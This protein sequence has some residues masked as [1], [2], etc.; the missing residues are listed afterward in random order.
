MSASTFKQILSDATVGGT[1]SHKDSEASMPRKLVSISSKSSLSDALKVL[2][3]NMIVSVPVIDDGKCVGIVDNIDIINYLNK[4]FENIREWL[5]NS[6]ASV[7]EVLSGILVSEIIDFAHGDPLVVTGEKA[8]I[9]SIMNLLVSGMTHRCVV[10]TQEGYGIISQYDII[11]LLAE[12]LKNNKDLQEE[13]DSIILLDRLNSRSLSD[14]TVTIGATASVFEVL[15]RM[16]QKQV[17]AV[18]VVDE[19]EDGKIVGNFSATD[20]LNVGCGQFKE[21]SLSVHEF[22]EKYSPASL[23]PV[24]I[25]A[26]GTSLANVIDMFASLGLHRLWIVDS[27]S[28]TSFPVGVVTLT[29]VLKIVHQM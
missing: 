22:L 11:K 7:E 3:D 2:N 10:N 8:T 27:G 15:D 16:V 5:S 26:E 14:E 1:L 12:T 13:C 19:M 21:F 23:C 25:E 9:Q 18:A 24:T 6:E 17:H 29:D 20:L 28:Q 4:Q